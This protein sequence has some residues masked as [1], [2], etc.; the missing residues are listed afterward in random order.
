[1][2]KSAIKSTQHAVNQSSL[3]ISVLNALLR[4]STNRTTIARFCNVQWCHENLSSALRYSRLASKSTPKQQ[5]QQLLLS[6][7]GRLL[8]DPNSIPE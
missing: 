6:D 1:M 8:T 4:S 2:N 5:A 7:S 3:L